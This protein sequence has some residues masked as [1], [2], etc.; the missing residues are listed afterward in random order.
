MKSVFTRLVGGAAAVLLIAPVGAREVSFEDGI[1]EQLRCDADPT[2]LPFFAAIDQTGRLET[3]NQLGYDSVSCYPIA[4]GI[5]VRGMTFDVICGFEEDQSIAGW[6]DYFYRG[7]G[8]SPGQSL[9][10][11]SLSSEAEMLAWVRDTLKVPD[12]ER[13]VGERFIPG[14]DRSG[15]E[16]SCSSWIAN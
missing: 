13:R 2:P 1:V 12:P 8:T 5:T 6:S 10:L 3:D 7:P 11:L 9:S 16:V 4:G 14:D 15:S